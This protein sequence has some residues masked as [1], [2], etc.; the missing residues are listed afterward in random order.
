MV[1]VDRTIDQL[2]VISEGLTGEETVVTDGQL[3]ITDGVKVEQRGGG[4]GGNAPA[5]SEPKK[6]AS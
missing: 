3:L 1:T 4:G 2:A 6:G 5:G